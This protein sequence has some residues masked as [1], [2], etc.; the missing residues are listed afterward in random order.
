MKIALQVLVPSRRS[1]DQDT[2]DNPVGGLDIC[3]V[4]ADYVRCRRIC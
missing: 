3:G 4:Q 2:L 1:L